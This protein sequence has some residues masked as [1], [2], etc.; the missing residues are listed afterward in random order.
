MDDINP[1][2]GT[3]SVNYSLIGLG[4]TPDG[5]T[6]GNNMVT[7]NPLI[8]LL[9]DNGGPTETHALLAGSPAIDTGDMAASPGICNVPLFDQR[10]DNY[11]R[12]QN[13]RIDIG[14]FEVRETLSADFDSSGFITGIDFLL[15][16]LGFGT[17]AADATKLDGDG[18]NDRDTDGSDLDVWENQFGQPAPAVSATSLLVAETS[19]VA[20]PSAVFQ[21]EVTATITS[22]PEE[23]LVSRFPGNIIIR[24]KKQGFRFTAPRQVLGREK[25]FTE[26]AFTNHID[27]A[28]SSDWHFWIKQNRDL[29]NDDFV[30]AKH[31]HSEKAIQPA[32]E[33]FAELAD[34]IDFGGLRPSL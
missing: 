22:T 12:V 29:A 13:G 14:A 6:S 16:Q 31:E 5:G 23:P 21:V 33:A 3:F 20:E 1:G 7:N 11:G 18:D 25:S 9:A 19:L 8:G 2:M 26:H 17:A 28:F 27:K 32:D 15:W 30:R 10:G 4:V 24:P 34:D